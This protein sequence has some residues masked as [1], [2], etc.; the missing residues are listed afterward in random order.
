MSVSFSFARSRSGVFGRS[1]GIGA[2]SSRPTVALGALVFAIAVFFGA[3]SA[4]ADEPPVVTIGNSPTVEY[5]TAPV[6]GTVNPSGGPSTTYWHFEYTTTPADDSSWQFGPSGEFSGPAAEGT[7]PVPVN[8]TIQGLQPG[9]QYSVRLVAE[10]GEFANR[11]VTGSPYPTFTTKGPVAKATVSI[12]PVTTFDDTTAHFSGTINPGAASSDPGFKVHYEFL[13]VPSCLN[14]DGQ[15]LG[16]QLP[17]D[18]SNH[19]VEATATELEPN[20]DY[21]V[22]LLATN[23]GGTESASPQSFHTTAIRPSAETVPAFAIQGGTEALVGARINPHN[24]ATTYWIE[25]GPTIAYGTSVPLSEDAS[26]GS[27][28]ASLVFTQK[29]GGLTP[30]TV[31]HFRVVAENAIGK[32]EGADKN[33]ETAPAGPA[34][35]PSCPNAALRA[36]NNSNALADCR[37]YEQVSPAD[38]DGFDAGINPEIR[39]QTYV[40]A[41]DGSALYFESFGGFGDVKTASVL[42]QYVSRR[43]AGGWETHGLAPAQKIKRLSNSAPFVSWLTPDL[44]FAAIEGGQQGH[45]APGDNPDISNGYRVDT[46]TGTYA[47][48]AAASLTATN[49]G[50]GTPDGKRIF[51]TSEDPLT[52]EATSGVDRAVYEWHE[53][54]L[55]VISILPNGE[56]APSAFFRI[57]TDTTMQNQVSSDGS[58]VVF[59]AGEPLQLYLRE[60]GERTISVTASR[61][62]STAESELFQTAYAG[63][64][65]DASKIFFETRGNLTPDASGGKIKLYRFEP[66]TETLTNLLAGALPDR[67]QAITSHGSYGSAVA[68]ISEDGEYVYFYSPNRFHPDDNLGGGSGLYL[69]HD[70]TVRFIGPDDGSMNTDLPFIP[71]RVSPDGKRLSFTS[72]A[73]MT[74]YDNTDS[75]P[76]EGGAPRQDTEVY[77]YDAAND[78]VTCI[79]CNP[80]GQRPAGAPNGGPAADSELPSLPTFQPLNR[81]PGVRNDGSIFFSSRDV[82]VPEDINGKMDVYEWKNGRVRLISSGSDGTDSFLA[83][84]SDSGDDVFFLTRERLVATDRDEA[85]DIYDARAGGGLPQ[86]RERSECE[87]I[88]G[89]QGPGGGMPSFA[90]PASGSFSS[91]LK[92]LRP[93]AQRLRK[94]LKACKHRKKKKARARCRAA[95]KKR[96]GKAPDGRTK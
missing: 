70:G 35:E 78:R 45:L 63:A 61:G 32:V 7:S 62:G 52:P 10:N 55:K 71:S 34:S 40:A 69:W 50:G 22:K 20:T 86:T 72:G 37:A 39:Q 65:A 43:S 58:R 89:C 59:K 77:V 25:Y 67:E 84:S 16:G 53:G 29:I 60:D 95:A 4:I 68:G 91:P 3:A 48:L 92:R 46:L 30:S 1:S 76:D 75:V 64:S 18:N 47:T 51:F 19:T 38:K 80:S 5:T 11:V 41:T 81:Q 14:P 85:L 54:Q 33:F 12:D 90:D 17:A 31:Y 36:E 15:P 66:D 27:G 42:N 21:S 6:S 44:R 9:T 73:R 49:V 26:V 96:Y 2:T 28:G 23:A 13:C 56:L 83:S 87:G 93:N 57:S 79:S 24:S 88:E 94:A 8:G 82:L 74:A